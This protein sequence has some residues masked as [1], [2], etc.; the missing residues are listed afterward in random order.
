MKVARPCTLYSQLHAG[1]VIFFFSKAAAPEMGLSFFEGTPFVLFVFF[2][3]AGPRKNTHTQMLQPSMQG[4][5][6]AD[7]CENLRN[8]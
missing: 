6:V 8:L 1:A 7:F 4:E 2:G 3:G 5:D